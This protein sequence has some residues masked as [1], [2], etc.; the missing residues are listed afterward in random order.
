MFYLF[1]VDR[2]PSGK[3][4]KEGKY[5][6]ESKSDQGGGEHPAPETGKCVTW[7]FI[8]EYE[9]WQNHLSSSCSYQMTLQESA[10]GSVGQKNHGILTS[11]VGLTSSV[12]LRRR[13]LKLVTSHLW[14]LDSSFIS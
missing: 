12:M 10:T 14:T 4:R 3:N 6:F 1:S 2:G 11:S 8:A 9:H 7:K 5:V 13:A